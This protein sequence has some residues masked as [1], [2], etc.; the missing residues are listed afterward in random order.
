MMDNMSTRE[1]CERLSR[2]NHETSRKM[3]ELTRA[4]RK[5]TNREASKEMIE[6]TRANREASENS[7]GNFKIFSGKGYL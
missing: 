6:L 3:I 1:V 7:A 2:A 4:N 5:R